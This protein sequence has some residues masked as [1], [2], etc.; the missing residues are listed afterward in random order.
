M[1]PATVLLIRHGETDWNLEKRFQGLSDIPLNSQGVEQARQIANA[2]KTQDVAAV[3]AS[4]LQ[5]TKQTGTVIA[6]TLG[7]K[8]S[9]DARLRERDLGLMQG[10]TSAQVQRDHPGVW[11]AWK[12]TSSTFPPEAGV[13]P[14]SGAVARM[15]AA[16]LDMAAAHPGKT[17]AVVSHGALIRLFLSSAVGTASITKLSVGGAETP[18]SW[19]VVKLSDDS[20]LRGLR[21]L[22]FFKDDD[23]EQWGKDTAE[24]AS[25][26]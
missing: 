21:G 11:A 24:P 18:S 5:R 6:E 14:G 20:H 2:L 15:Q 23:E 22:G 26:L 8:L 17:V 4:P 12:A 13:E 3:W 19:Q 25:K 1:K 7:L 16:L 10:M 9:L